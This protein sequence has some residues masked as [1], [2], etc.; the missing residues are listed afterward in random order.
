[1]GHRRGLNKARVDDGGQGGPQVGVRN[2]CLQPQM[3]SVCSSLAM[4]D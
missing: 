1:M 3:R 2:E 4:L